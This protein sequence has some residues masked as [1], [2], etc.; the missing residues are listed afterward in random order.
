MSDFRENLSSYLDAV[1]AG[2]TVTVMRRGK[3]SATLSAAQSL[4]APIDSA[5]LKAF[6]EE[7]EIDT[8]ENAVVSNR[9]D[10]RY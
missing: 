4:P 1:E 7:L 9:R 2:K 5:R 3:P 6:R 8:D 10:E